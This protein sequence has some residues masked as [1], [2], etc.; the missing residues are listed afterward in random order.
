METIDA[1]HTFQFTTHNQSGLQWTFNDI[2]LVDSV[3]NEP[4]SHGYIVY[5]VKPIAGL[6]VG[7]S[8]ANSATIYFDFNPGVRTNTQL[9]LIGARPIALPQPIVT[10]L[11][12]SYCQLNGIQKGQIANLPLTGTVV[13]LDNVSLSVAADSLQTQQQCRGVPRGSSRRH[14]P[15]FLVHESLPFSTVAVSSIHR[16]IH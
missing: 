15:T 8:I 4:L 9:T 6:N 14:E 11:K 7:D 5:R 2:R 3:H 1:S 12:S 13:K 10:K 16:G